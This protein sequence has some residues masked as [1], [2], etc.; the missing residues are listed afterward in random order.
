MENERQEC[1]LFIESQTEGP[2]QNSGDRRILYPQWRWRL[3]TNPHEYV[4][5]NNRSTTAHC[6]HFI[7]RGHALCGAEH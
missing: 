5:H 6:R 3:N 2:N 7:R 4:I 1:V